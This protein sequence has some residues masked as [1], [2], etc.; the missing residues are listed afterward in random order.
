MLVLVPT[1]IDEENPLEQTALN[2]LKSACDD[3]SLI[4]IEDLKPGRRRWIRWGLPRE[5][6][7]DLILYN[8]HTRDKLNLE[9]VQK[10]KS[11]KKLFLMS[12][13]GLPAFCDPGQELVNLCHLEGIKVTS[14]PF[15]N[16]TIL[17][18]ALSG[19]PHHKFIFEGFLSAKKEERGKELKKILQNPQTIIL[20]DTPYRLKSLLQSLENTSPKR[21]VFLGMDLNSKEETLLRDLPKNIL[22]KLENFK[23]EFV[24]VLSPL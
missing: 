24:L 23:R 14:T 21:Q 7:D 20:M 9:L 19:F 13:G 16:S 22:Q 3:G 10:M 5:K 18:L 11:G 8:E 17:A 12:D 4:A 1:P 6:V 15:Y 2:L